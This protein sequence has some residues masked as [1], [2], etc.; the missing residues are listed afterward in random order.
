MWLNVVQHFSLFACLFRF[1]VCFRDGSKG[2]ST[3]A[4]EKT[5]MVSERNTQA[6]KT[7]ATSGQDATSMATEMKMQEILGE[8]REL[9]QKFRLNEMELFKLRYEQ[10]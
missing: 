3:T 2:H 5:A 8:N 10:V 9:K 7:A 4:L 6:L 1:R